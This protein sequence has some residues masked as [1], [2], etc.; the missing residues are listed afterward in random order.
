MNH[1]IDNFIIIGEK[2]DLKI[3]NHKTYTKFNMGLIWD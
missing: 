1:K 3:Q 2:I